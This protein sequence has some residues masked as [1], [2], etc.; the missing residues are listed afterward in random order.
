MKNL[1]FAVIKFIVLLAIRYFLCI[2][3]FDAFVV[4]FYSKCT[5]I[6]YNKGV[7]NSSNKTKQ[8]L[9]IYYLIENV[10]TKETNSIAKVR[11]IITFAIFVS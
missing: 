3:D 7:I 5:N 2:V 11:E 9:S 8:K 10:S 1:I 4:E 6:N